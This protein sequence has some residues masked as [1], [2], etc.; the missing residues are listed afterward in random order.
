[1]VATTAGLLG[2]VAVLD[3][4]FHEEKKQNCEFVYVHLTSANK[5][6]YVNLSCNKVSLEEFTKIMNVSIKSCE[7]VA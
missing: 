1:M 5:V 2:P 7:T 6:A 4:I 3:L